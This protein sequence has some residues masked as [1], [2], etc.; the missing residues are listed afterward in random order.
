MVDSSPSYKRS[1]L[2]CMVALRY[3]QVCRLFL[4]ALP[5]LTCAFHTQG[6]LVVQDGCL[7]LQPAPSHSWQK[8]G[9]GNCSWIKKGHMLAVL[10]LFVEPSFISLP[11]SQRKRDLG[12]SGFCWT[13]CHPYQIRIYLLKQNMTQF[14]VVNCQSLVT[15]TQ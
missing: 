3:Y 5:S 4:F 8:V 11:V 7:D 9:R 15:V 2:V 1:D 12:K 6:Y 10:A 14:C 13:H